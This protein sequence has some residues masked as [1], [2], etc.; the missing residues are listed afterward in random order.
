MGLTGVEGAFRGSCEVSLGVLRNSKTILLSVL[1]SFVVDPL[2]EWTRSRQGDAA[3]NQEE[4]AKLQKELAREKYN[5]IGE[6]LSGIV[7]DRELLAQQSKHG[8]KLT[9]RSL[10]RSPDQTVAPG[11]AN[12]FETLPV[13]VQGQVERLIKE[14]I[15]EDKLS[16]MFGKWKMLL[17]CEE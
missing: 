14:A 15:D 8:Q 9:R 13:S 16:R 6:R 4:Q 2:V 10:T 7:R 12:T 17:G 1:E 5:G 3:T 11:I